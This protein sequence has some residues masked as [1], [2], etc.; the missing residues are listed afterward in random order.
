LIP[1]QHPRQ[2]RQRRW[3]RISWWYSLVLLVPI[4]GIIATVAWSAGSSKDGVSGVVK[5][6]YTGKPVSNALI[7]TAN[8]TAHS[9]GD[10]SFSVDDPNASA[11]Q[12]SKDDYESTQVPV[13]KADDSLQIALRPTT[14]T[15]TVKNTK[16]GKPIVGASITVVGQ[17]DVSATAITDDKGKYSINKVPPDATIT[18]VYDNYT[19]VTKPVGKSVTIDFDVKP[20]VVTGTVVDEAGQPVAGATVAVGSAKTTTGPDG[21]YKLGGIPDTGQLSITKAGYVAVNAEVPDSLKLDA[22]L[23]VFLV[24]ALYVSAG[25]AAND[26]AWKHILD[27]A[28]TTEINAVVLDLKDSSGEVFYDTNV[29]LATEIG[30]KHVMYDIRAK[31]KDMHDH[32]IYAIGRLVSFE[33]PILAAAKPELAIHDVTTGGLWKTFNDLA[34]V[35]AHERPV[36]QYNVDLA[37]EAATDGFDEIQLDYIRFPTDGLVDNMDF[38]ADHADESMEDAIAGYTKQMHDALQ[39]TGAYLGV[40]V[41]GLTMWDDGDGGIGQNLMLISPNVDIICPMIYPSHFAP[42]DMGLDLPNDHPHEV[43]LWS[44]QHGAERVGIPTSKLRPWLQDFSYGDG[45]SYGDQEVAAQIAAAKEAN[46]GGWMLWNAANE[47]H[48]AALAPQ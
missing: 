48:E 35:N 5:D 45:I 20:D 18:V 33:D 1:E 38:G 16:T 23:K 31:L 14:L 24:K 32:N 34:W 6:A 8:A 46:A 27:L 7:S 29:P 28:D 11:L 26:D 2:A 21:T 3:E 41:F 4:I 13:S 44:I 47:F 12:V 25:A 42:G 40:D 36:W 10:G 9:G 22:T 19:I 15:G 17:N 37:T 30:A 43:I 39:P